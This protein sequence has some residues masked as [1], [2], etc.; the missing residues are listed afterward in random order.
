MLEY[1]DLFFAFVKVG[2]DPV[3]P[4]NLLNTDIGAETEINEA[5]INSA[6][7]LCSLD[8]RITAAESPTSE[9]RTA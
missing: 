3:L 5:E 2:S 7:M 1:N 4:R 9:T 8:P 6:G